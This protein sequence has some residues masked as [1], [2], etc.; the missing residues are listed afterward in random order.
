MRDWKLIDSAPHDGS[1]ISV[2]D[3]HGRQAEAWWDKQKNYWR[4]GGAHHGFP[5]VPE[6]DGHAWVK[7]RPQGALRIIP[8]TENAKAWLNN[9]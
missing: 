7:W 3:A 1:E 9:P 4:S 5:L 2:R 8:L 6:L